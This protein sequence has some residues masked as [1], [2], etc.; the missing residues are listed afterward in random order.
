MEPFEPTISKKKNLEDKINI[1]EFIEQSEWEPI[2]SD[3]DQLPN[4]VIL[5]EDMISI[6]AH[7]KPLEKKT[8]FY[9]ND[10][11]KT[12]MMNIFK[13]LSQK[14]RI[15]VKESKMLTGSQGIGKSYSLNFLA[16]YL[17]TCLI[18]D[19]I[20]LVYIKDCSLLNSYG[21]DAFLYEL[22]FAFPEENLQWNS[23]NSDKA[24]N[25]IHSFKNCNDQEYLQWN[26]LNDNYLAKC[27]IQSYHDQGYF[28]ILICDQLN[29][30]KNSQNFNFDQIFQLDWTLQILSQSANNYYAP[31][32][33]KILKL[34]SLINFDNIINQNSLQEL[35]LKYKK[36][37]QL[38]LNKQ[39]NYEK[40]TGLVGNNPREAF[41][42]LDQPGD[43]LEN[44]I[45]CYKIKREPEIYRILN[46]LVKQLDSEEKYS[47]AKSI[48]YMDTNAFIDSLGEP[49]V[50]LQFMKFFKHKDELDFYKIESLFPFASDLIKAFDFNSSSFKKPENYYDL[51]FDEILN[52][53]RL[54][55][56]ERSRGDLF[57][58]LIILC[59]QCAI[60][61]RKEINLNF[62]LTEH[63]ETEKNINFKVRL[64]FCF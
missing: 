56:N 47:L 59:F 10:I 55:I 11:R 27:L 46:K 16:Y 41:L 21:Y 9:L 39:E 13:N 51:K 18:K 64:I 8:V 49:V 63:L 42:L 32:N 7:Y 57:E 45:E 28:T 40:I 53:Y 31:E 34:C 35:L 17:R 44:K 60:D 52:L 1:S 26:C 20:K 58:K 36:N 24:M 50:I 23:L 54:A 37:S 2:L 12:F 14:K 25:L 29:S 43:L 30:L 61:Q 22:S 38:L 33:D 15:D 5:D 48:Y 4:F 19:K 3:I 6:I 62:C